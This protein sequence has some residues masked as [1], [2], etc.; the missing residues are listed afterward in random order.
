MDLSLLRLRFGKTSVSKEKQVTFFSNS[1]EDHVGQVYEA[2]IKFTPVPT[3]TLH[4]EL[5]FILLLSKF[6]LTLDFSLWML[7]ELT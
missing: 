1:L 5:I 3:A 2:F 7:L 4:C 6:V